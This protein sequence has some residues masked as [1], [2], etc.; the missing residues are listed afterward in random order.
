[1]AQ[2]ARAPGRGALPDVVRALMARPRAQLGD[3][4]TGA[5]YADALFA[6]AQWFESHFGAVG[7]YPRAPAAMGV[8]LLGYWDQ[9]FKVAI[10]SL[11]PAAIT[12]ALPDA[13][14][15][16]AARDALDAALT[17][18][19]AFAA[20]DPDSTPPLDHLEQLWD[21]AGLVVAWSDVHSKTTPQ[22]ISLTAPAPA[23]VP[24]PF[25]RKKPPPK[26]GS[27]KPGLG[28]WVM[29]LAV[30]IFATRRR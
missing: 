27:R 9:T 20:G 4:I 16:K 13:A 3:D 24:P 6:Q 29:L 5:T 28:G 7:D 22:K 14:D 8:A 10:L 30:L 17:A 21:A 2:H 18:W 12:T 15:A 11:G 1:M 25:G 19:K 23:T 26:P